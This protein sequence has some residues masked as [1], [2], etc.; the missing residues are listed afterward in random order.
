MFCS[1]LPLS[2]S[3]YLC[4]C[5]CVCVCA[6]VCVCLCPFMSGCAVYSTVCICQSVYVIIERERVCVCVFQ[7][8]APNE[9]SRTCMP[10]PTICCNKD[11][12]WRPSN[13]I[14]IR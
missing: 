8:S 7:Q 4:V 13:P 2:L 6:F 12:F 11:T 5:V 1:S 9:L 3:L 14:K 10:E